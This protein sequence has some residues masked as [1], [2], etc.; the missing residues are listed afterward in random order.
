MRIAV[1]LAGQWRTGLY[2]YPYLKEIFDDFEYVDYHIHTWSINNSKKLAKIS[3]K[4]TNK[5]WKQHKSM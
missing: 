3:K 1:I 2:C 4:I 5:R